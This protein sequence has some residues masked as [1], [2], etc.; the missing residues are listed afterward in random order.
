MRTVKAIAYNNYLEAIRDKILYV[1]VAFAILLIASSL[2]L[3][4]ISLDQDIKIVKDF[5][6]AGI[7]FFGVL[8]AVFVGANSIYK[9]KEKRTIYTILP[10]PIKHWE[11]ILGKFLGLCLTLAVTTSLMTI[12][13]V[14]V[15]LI[16]EHTF[17]LLLLQAILFEYMELIL[18]VSVV[19]A[20]SSFTSPISAAIYTICLFAIGHSTS[21]I[22]Q[23]ASKSGSVVLSKTL[24]GVYYIFPNLEKFNLKTNV[25]FGIGLS[26]QEIIFT[27]IYALFYIALMLI[28]AT[29]IL[30]KQEF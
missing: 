7:F 4:S 14:I 27:I 15:S 29:L 25:V 21:I 13:L 11:F 20:F 26:G 6:L 18:L 19:L 9:E 23:L 30:R 5:G 10:K 2:I 28:L 1:F 24:M 12:A 3:G 22:Y 16:K 17:Q 8:I